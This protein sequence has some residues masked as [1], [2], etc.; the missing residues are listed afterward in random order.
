M[1]VATQ[2][3]PQTKLIK[4]TKTHELFICFAQKTILSLHI[5]CMYDFRSFVQYR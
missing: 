4:Q 5:S 1:F 3:Q 2:T